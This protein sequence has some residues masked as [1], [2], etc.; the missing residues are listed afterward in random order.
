M[1]RRELLVLA[2]APAFRPAV[3]TPRVVYISA[4][5]A[6]GRFV[7]D[8]T[9][10]DLVV[11]END[12]PREV[13]AL[14]RATELCHIA[15]LV[16]DG[17][18]GLLQGPV[19]D[20]LNTA[21]GRAAF[22]ISMLNPQAVRLNDYATN[23][24]TLKQSAERLVQRGRLSRDTMMLVDA[25][26]STARDIEKRKLSRPVIVAL[27][28]GGE[29]SDPDVAKDILRNLAASGASLHVAHVVGAP[30]GQVLAEGPPRSGGSSTVV[31]SIEG[32]SKAVD[33]VAAT[34]ANQYKLTYALPADVKPGER[35]QV[36]SKRSQ[37]RIVAPTSVPNK[38]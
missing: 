18:N 30:I 36:T 22:S 34:L 23:P 29:S 13:T 9:A 24:E 35:L 21:E 8:L 3:A 26:A 19:V 32:F 16:D 15:V 10:D 33:R 1:T 25:V 38:V 17:G 12:K 20:L 5:D 7:T 6:M 4:I 27:T 37:V 31:T 28:N 14:T 11:K 2:V